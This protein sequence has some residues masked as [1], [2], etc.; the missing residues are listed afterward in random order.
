MTAFTDDDA[1]AAARSAEVRELIDRAQSA[2]VLLTMLSAMD[3]C[4][5]GGPRQALFDEA[6]ARAWGSLRPKGRKNLPGVIFE[7]LE[8]RGLLIR[9]APTVPLAAPD[10][11]VEP[12]ARDYAFSPK[13]GAVMAARSRP[14][15][16]VTCELKKV[17]SRYPRLYALGDEQD[18]V[19]A[20]VLETPE[21]PEPGQ[22]QQVDRAGPLGWFYRYDLISRQSAAD[23]LAGWALLRSKRHPRA[24]RL[25]TLLR[26]DQGNA[27]TVRTLEIYTDD[28]T[29]ARLDGTQYD[30]TE[31]TSIMSSLLNAQQNPQA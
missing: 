5:L 16:A 15:V 2:N 4:A 28:G 31:V 20:M 22:F 21:A 11:H 7:E 29:T 30:K 17:P 8:E 27:L 12:E 1:A 14:A 19:R 26:F 3:L 18:R 23:F 24:P 13:L 6:P 9:Q 10:G 25:V